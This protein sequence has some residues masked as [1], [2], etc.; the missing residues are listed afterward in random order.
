MRGTA[1]PRPSASRNVARASALT[2]SGLFEH[3]GVKP[4]PTADC[5]LV[6]GLL[7][8]AHPFI[9]VLGHH[10]ELCGHQPDCDRAV[11]P[12]PLDASFG[13]PAAN[14]LAP[15]LWEHSEDAEIGDVLWKPSGLAIAGREIGDRPN[16]LTG[17]L[18]DENDSLFVP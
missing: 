11:G 16:Q 9:H 3:P 12:G 14:A 15:M 7:H 17:Q 5:A 18:G 8:K 13:E 2:T 1:G 6:L 10:H 4:E